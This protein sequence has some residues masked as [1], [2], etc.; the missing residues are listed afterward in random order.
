MD[1]LQELWRRATTV[2]PVPEPT[3]VAL[4]AV[5]A[6]VTICVAWPVVRMLTTITHEGGHAIV[7][8]LTG[9]TVTGIRLNSD[10]SGLTL[11]RGR[12][13]GP[14]MLATLVAGY[15]SP[16]LVGLGA[17]WLLSTGRAVGLLWFF[18]V[19][20]AVMLLFIRNL[21]GVL[22]MV[23]ALG[24]V[25]A[26]SWFLPPEHQSIVAYTLTWL[27]LFA[28]PRPVIELF[29]TPSPGS[30][31]AQL[32]RLTGLGAGV[33]SSVFLLVTVACLMAGVAILVPGVVDAARG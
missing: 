24:G 23:V 10:T 20:L 19:L 12:P 28:G 21:F 15:V 4:L 11:S 3:T 30:D 18:T 26:A 2:Q 32:G 29:R 1:L 6:L 14:G 25:G 17:A 33:W 13:T 7:A 16:G 5:I 31:A 8:A 27:L 22:T 9:R